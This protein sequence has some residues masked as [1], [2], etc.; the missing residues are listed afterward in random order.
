MHSAR[1]YPIKPSSPFP[2]NPNW[3]KWKTMEIEM[4]PCVICLY[5]QYFISATV[6]IYTGLAMLS[7]KKRKKN[8][9]SY[10]FFIRFL[11]T[12]IVRTKQRFYLLPCHKCVPSSLFHFSRFTCVL[13]VFEPFSVF[14]LSVWCNIL[15][16]WKLPFLLSFN[17]CVCDMVSVAKI[18][19]SRFHC[20]WIW[21]YEMLHYFT[22]LEF[23][24][25]AQQIERR[26][27]NVFY[28]CKSMALDEWREEEEEEES[29]R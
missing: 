27:E 15:G 10:V 8:V 28:E 23:C 17:C 11:E 25:Q 22:L 19:F 1:A 26:R 21:I 9:V 4:V 18:F 29:E 24:Q 13:H 6:W 5:T 12:H 7:N 14:S 16:A 20:L 2:N 3:I